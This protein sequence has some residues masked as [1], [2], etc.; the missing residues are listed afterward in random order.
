VGSGCRYSPAGRR[1]ISGSN[2]PLHPSRGTGGRAFKDGS[3]NHYIILLIKLGFLIGK[4]LLQL[5]NLSYNR[6]M[7]FSFSQPYPCVL[8]RSALQ[9][10][11]PSFLVTLSR[12]SYLRAGND[13]FSRKSYSGNSKQYITSTSGSHVLMSG[14][15]FYPVRG[16]VY[17]VGSKF[18][19]SGRQ[20]YGVG[21]EFNRSGSK[22]NRRGSQPY[23][24]GSEFDRPGSRFYEPEN[25]IYL[26]RSH[27]YRVGNEIYQ[28]RRITHKEQRHGSPEYQNIY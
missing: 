4:Y 1:S 27:F 19:R 13:R 26:C 2:R 20:S 11:R 22:F 15:W 28:A 12:L 5:I 23:R 21:I 8:P 10:H 6:L 7:Q 16:H 18:N 9:S 24:E 25:E 14:S 3:L 17:E